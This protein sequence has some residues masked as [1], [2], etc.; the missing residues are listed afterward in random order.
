MAD[1]LG[2]I[3][4]YTLSALKKGLKLEIIV[5]NLKKEGHKEDEIKQAFRAILDEKKKMTSAN[6][7]VSQAI[8]QPASPQESPKAGQRVS[9][10]ADIDF[11]IFARRPYDNFEKL[12]PIASIA[13]IAT[14]LPMI[15]IIL[16]VIV[17]FIALS[18]KGAYLG[19]MLLGSGILL[20]LDILYGWLF[21][22]KFVFTLEKNCL[23]VR[24]GVITNSYTLIP[25][26]NIQDVHIVQSLIG[27]IFRV[28]SVIIFTATATASGSELV[29]GL[30]KESADRFREKIF[31]KMKEAKHVTD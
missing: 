17:A 19:L 9:G 15:A 11:L 27:R 5:K 29:P 16:A 3:K 6:Q 20:F 4:E 23:L 13:Y 10:P 7:H 25:Y 18:T 31:L 30:G 2:E 14:N 26:E 1:K 28:W 21:I 22:S 12:S 8:S 24:K